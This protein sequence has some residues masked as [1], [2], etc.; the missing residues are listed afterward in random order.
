M[1]GAKYYL[2]ELSHPEKAISIFTHYSILLNSFQSYSKGQLVGIL[3]S[4][5]TLLSFFKFRVSLVNAEK[6][7]LINIFLRIAKMDQKV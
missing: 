5:L 3:N 7:K 1:T 4:Q 2:T 6:P